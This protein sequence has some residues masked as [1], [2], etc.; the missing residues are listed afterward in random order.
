MRFKI[1]TLGLLLMSSSMSYAGVVANS[2]GKCGYEDE[3]GKLIIDYKY[4]FIGTFDEHGLA[5]VKSGKK[6]GMIDRTGKIVLPISYDFI[7]IFRH[8]VAN[9]TQGKKVGL[10]SEDGKV[11]LKPTYT[12]ISHFN[13]DGLAMGEINAKKKNYA[14]INLKGEV[15]I[16]SIYHES[17][18]QI[19]PE[20][21]LTKIDL[22]NDTLDSR[23]GYFKFI[24]TKGEIY[25]NLKGE[26]VINNAKFTE[27]YKELLNT[28]F[29]NA[30]STP[31]KGAWHG[32][33]IIKEDVAVCRLCAQTDKKSYTFVNAYYDVAKGKLLTSY[34]FVGQKADF[35]RKATKEEMEELR[36]ALSLAYMDNLTNSNAGMWANYY[37]VAL[38]GF[39]IAKIPGATTAHPFHEGFAVVNHTRNGVET[40]IL[41]NREGKEVGEYEFLL[42]YKNGY[43]VIADASKKYG[44]IDAKQNNTV[45]CQYAAL[46]ERSAEGVNKAGYLGVQNDEGL[47][48]VVRAAD[49]AVVVPFEYDLVIPTRRTQSIF[50]HKGDRWGIYCDTVVELACDNDSLL[51]TI[52]QSVSGYNEGHYFVYNYNEKKYS[53]AYDG[54]R[55]AYDAS[56]KYHGGGC[57]L[58]SKLIEGVPYYGFV[59]ANA[60]EMLPCVFPKEEWAFK[61]LKAYRDIPL[62]EFDD[63]DRYRLPLK[64]ST[65]ER[66][67]QL[68]DIVPDNDWDF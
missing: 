14:I 66:T 24:S 15:V 6:Y 32:V 28:K 55:D 61:A 26:E 53:D 18:F 10:L 42:P 38:L 45:P 56:E 17:F 46:A 3:N 22:E 30:A 62:E 12:D 43:A 51:W 25:Y 13:S 68:T 57:Y 60:V 8:G 67:Y 20:G 11:L 65:R 49:N 41:I 19:N 2:K 35:D 4:D 16:P 21:E 40:S 44:L 64:F 59:N 34:S 48:G 47:W 31:L 54:C 37:K 58:V 50:V 36:D 52:G 33:T 5:R 39:R 27:L 29:K 1:L 23:S 63:I 9:L 7:G